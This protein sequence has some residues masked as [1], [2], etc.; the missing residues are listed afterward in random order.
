[1]KGEAYYKRLVAGE[2]AG[3]PDRLLLGLLIALSIPYALFMR[4]RAS[5][6]RLGVIPSRRLPRPMISVGNLTMGGTGKT[7]MT[8]FLARELMARGKRVVV[9]TRG[10]GG[11]KE[12]ET[13]IVADD[14]GLLLGPEE[15]G[16]EPS[17]LASSLPGLMVV[18]GANRFSAGELAME[19]L[20]PD[21]FLIDDGFQHLRL[22]RDLDILLLDG[23]APFATGRTTPAGMLREPPSAAGR[24][25][26]IV[27]T[28]CPDGIQPEC[29]MPYAIPRVTA[30]H[31]LAGFRPLTG[32]ECRPLSELSGRRPLA[33]AGIADPAAFFDGLEGEGVALVATI[34]FPDHTAYG[35]QEMEA[36]GRLKQAKKADCIITTAKDAVKLQPYRGILRDCYVAELEL[37]LHDTG[38]LFAAL[39]KILH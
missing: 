33:F 14:T 20:Q 9:L 32:G 13:L 35:P 5:L 6:Y 26:L 17:L 12:G 2:A 25:D 28:R 21:L 8:L 39:D 27:F 31:R 30:S 23:N 15:A 18:M 7:P 1:M 11:S 37:V 24:A 34:A 22:K 19:R 4:C 36:I 29:A 10:Y 38:P 16:D 3:L